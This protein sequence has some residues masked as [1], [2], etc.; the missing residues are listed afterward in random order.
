MK[1]DCG[2]ESKLSHLVQA[3]VAV[4]QAN[5]AKGCGG[6]RS[7]LIGLIAG[8]GDLG[9]IRICLFQVPAIVLAP[10]EVG[11]GRS[12][13]T[14]GRNPF[15]PELLISSEAF[16]LSSDMSLED[17]SQTGTRQ[18][19]KNGYKACERSVHA[20]RVSEGRPDCVPLAAQ[21]SAHAAV[22][23]AANARTPVIR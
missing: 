20:A 3:R 4:D 19:C 18:R 17:K 21:K 5:T 6:L 16:C 14:V 9:T 23:A 11:E 22:R 15:V 7:P 8:T 13:G 10:A 12:E 2:I 1:L